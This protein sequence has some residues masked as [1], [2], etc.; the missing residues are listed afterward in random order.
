MLEKVIADFFTLYTFE[1][2]ISLIK[3]QKKKEGWY[4]TG[5]AVDCKKQIKNVANSCSNFVG[6][7]S[8]LT[9]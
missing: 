3:F 4:V 9:T 5:C 8:D 6:I 7:S 1:D 2:P